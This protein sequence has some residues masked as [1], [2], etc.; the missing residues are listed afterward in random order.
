MC[1]QFLSRIINTRCNL[2]THISNASCLCYAHIDL[3]KPNFLENISSKFVDLP[4]WALFQLA[5]SNHL[6]VYKI[7]DQKLHFIFSLNSFVKLKEKVHFL[8]QV[9]F[10][11]RKVFLNFSQSICF[12][13]GFAFVCWIV[14]SLLLHSFWCI[15]SF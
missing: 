8:Y 10:E 13:S 1:C 15:C 14:W 12:T 7:N 4:L 2:F 6:L 11:F 9:A 3:G 5:C